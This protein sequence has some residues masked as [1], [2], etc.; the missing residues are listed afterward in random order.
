MGHTTAVFTFTGR[1]TAD[2][3]PE[4]QAELRKDTPVYLA[5][6]DSFEPDLSRMLSPKQAARHGKAL[7]EVHG[8]H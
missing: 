6:K 8:T 5:L 3:W 2:R 1:E 7:P 4:D